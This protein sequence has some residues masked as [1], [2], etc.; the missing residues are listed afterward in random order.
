MRLRITLILF[1]AGLVTAVS[2]A[3]ERTI[4]VTTEVRAS[5]SEVWKAWTTT[6]GIASFFAPESK[7]DLRPNGAFEMYFD[8]SAA[9]GLRGGE[10][11]E[12]LALDPE[13]MISFT[14]NAPPHLKT[15]RNQRTWVT[16]HFERIDDNNTRVKLTNGGFGAGGE[17][18]KSFEY[19]SKAWPDYVMKSLRE[20]FEKKPVTR[21]KTR[22]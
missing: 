2:S 3:S 1:A 6:E 8:P 9:D 12:F 4:V 10:G 18:E 5:V 11:N 19:F 21:E 15:V 22:H 20:R 14:W 16:V 7:I 17:W 13:K